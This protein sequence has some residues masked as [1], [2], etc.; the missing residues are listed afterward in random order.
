MANN[1][2]K[3]EVGKVYIGE[4]RHHSSGNVLDTDLF[5]CTKITYR[6]TR[7]SAHPDEYVSMHEVYSR[8][9][10]DLHWPTRV[11]KISAWDGIE[12]VHNAGLHG[13]YSVYA[14]KEYH[15][16]WYEPAPKKKSKKKDV[17]IMKREL[18]L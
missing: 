18:E 17:P 6:E 8:P 15:G 12:H 14:N 2:V 3:F 9:D 10:V 1:I 16:K 13:M 5:L 7:W 11:C 4:W